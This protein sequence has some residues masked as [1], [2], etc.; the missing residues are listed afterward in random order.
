MG[1]SNVHRGTISSNNRVG[2]RVGSLAVGGK[3]A[4]KRK[5]YVID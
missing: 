1:G 2:Y 4:F 3:N 5:A